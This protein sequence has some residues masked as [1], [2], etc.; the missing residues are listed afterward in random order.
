MS[1]HQE[2]RKSQL[3]EQLVHPSNVVFQKISSHNPILTV[4]LMCMGKSHPTI[5]MLVISM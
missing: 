2:V 4:V 5:K 3:D 1:L